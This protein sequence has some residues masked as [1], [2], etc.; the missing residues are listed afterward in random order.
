MRAI[1]LCLLLGLAA[2]TG[3]AIAHEFWIEPLDYQ[4][5]PDANLEGHIVNGQH[6]AGTEIAYFPQRFSRFDVILGDQT[7]AVTGRSGDRP[8]LTAAPLGDGLHIIAYVATQSLVTYDDYAAFDRFVTHK[9]FQGVREAHLLRALPET[10]FVEAYTRYVKSLIGVGSAAGED[11]YLGLPIEI[12]ALDNP[13]TAD[14]GAGLRVQVHEG[15]GLRGYGQVELF[16]KAADGTVTITL[17]RT[18][19]DGIALL[20]VIAGHSYL[21]DA[22]L[23]REPAPGPAINSGA[24]WE[25]LW[26]SLTFAI[27]E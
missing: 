24:V 4:I 27:P 23:L 22:V 10:G 18:D 14:V 20:P 2:W 11:S 3:P 19:A 7:A 13:Y 12:V 15:D 17:H 25:S 5:D 9:D 1:S 6:F 21:I 26:A 8:A 16:D